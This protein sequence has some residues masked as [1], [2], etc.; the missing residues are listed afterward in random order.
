V[1]GGQPLRVVTHS[2]DETRALGRRLGERL[3]DPA[4]P[5][6]LL[7]LRGDYGTGKTTFVQGLAAGLGVR[8]PARSP[9]YLIVKVYDSPG[10]A[11]RLVHADLYRV[12]SMAEADDLGIDELAGP[13]GVVAVEWPGAGLVPSA[14]RDC[15]DIEFNYEA[16]QAQGA[17]PKA[18][19][20][21]EEAKAEHH[22]GP[23]TGA[24]ASDP[25]PCALH[26]A[27][28]DSRALAF[29]ASTPEFE[30]VLRAIAAR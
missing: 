25:A 29:R 6:P 3:A 18:Q 21:E 1:S 7:L 20:G 19:T 24:I 13:Q 27:P 26:L 15:I 14:G 11:R 10:Q 28:A 12:H 30:E 23:E 9:S 4:L 22:V 17:R 16:K 5:A 2:A 8:E